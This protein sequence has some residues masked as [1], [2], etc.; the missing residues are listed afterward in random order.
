MMVY[1]N[2]LVQQVDGVP[3][4]LRGDLMH[5]RQEAFQK[6]LLLDV[7]LVANQ[8]EPAFWRIAKLTL[9]DG[10]ALVVSHRFGYWYI[11]VNN[12]PGVHG[13][14]SY[15]ALGYVNG[16][17]MWNVEDIVGELSRLMNLSH[18]YGNLLAADAHFA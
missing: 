18:R 16:F 11:S 8:Y 7:N 17:A 10:S 3:N 4:D 13:Y 6:G 2:H 1:N 15:P 5:I 14:P 12:P 9:T